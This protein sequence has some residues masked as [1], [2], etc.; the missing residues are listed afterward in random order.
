M[1]EVLC[2][3]FVK[4]RVAFL[5]VGTVNAACVRMYQLFHYFLRFEQ[6]KGTVLYLLQIKIKIKIK[7]PHKIWPRVSILLARALGPML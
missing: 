6:Q 2:V 5:F 4:L 7:S 1:S 3:I